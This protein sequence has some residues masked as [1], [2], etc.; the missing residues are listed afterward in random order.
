[1]GT[2]K[3]AAKTKQEK[4]AAKDRVNFNFMPTIIEY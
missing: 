1:M 3:V 2:A 4:I